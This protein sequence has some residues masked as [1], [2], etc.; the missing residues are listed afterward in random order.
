MYKYLLDIIKKV[1]GNIIGIGLE[2]I[3]LDG[4]NKNNKVNVYTIC[5]DKN[6]EVYGLVNEKK[7]KLV[8]VEQ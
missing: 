6:Q 1:E 8:L 4:F 3:L 5:E 7:E 2:G